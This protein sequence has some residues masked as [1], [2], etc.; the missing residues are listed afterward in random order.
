MVTAQMFFEA[1]L[2]RQDKSPNRAPGYEP[3]EVLDAFKEGCNF[4]FTLAA[5]KL[6]T[7]A[8]DAVLSTSCRAAPLRPGQ[9]VKF[10]DPDHS[11]ATALHEAQMAIVDISREVR[12]QIGFKSEPATEKPEGWCDASCSSCASD[13]DYRNEHG[14]E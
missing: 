13:E 10:I 4:A 11:V 14:D 3:H 8:N 5:D 9:P 2:E 7:L 12:A 6:R 1:W